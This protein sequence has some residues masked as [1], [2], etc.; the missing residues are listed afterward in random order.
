MESFRGSFAAVHEFL[1]GQQGT[2][3]FFFQM[4]RKLCSYVV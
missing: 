2:F 4:G 1:A 3:N